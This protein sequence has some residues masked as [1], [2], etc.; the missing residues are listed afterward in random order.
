[1]TQTELQQL[2]ICMCYISANPLRTG[3]GRGV[4]RY[5]SPNLCHH[6]T[7]GISLSASKITGVKGKKPYGKR[8]DLQSVVFEGSRHIIP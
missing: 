5:S 6:Y 1:M 3:K 4:I 7:G 8:Q 2:F